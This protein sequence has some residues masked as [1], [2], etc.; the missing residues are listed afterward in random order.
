MLSIHGLLLP[1]KVGENPIG[2]ALESL[3]EGIE[4]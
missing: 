4:A 3:I 1:E 2:S